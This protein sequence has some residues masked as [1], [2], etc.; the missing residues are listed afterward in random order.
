[1]SSVKIIHYRYGLS[2][3]MLLFGHFVLQGI[4]FVF[5]SKLVFVLFCFALFFFL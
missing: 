2:I 1:M 4:A 5:G 3:V